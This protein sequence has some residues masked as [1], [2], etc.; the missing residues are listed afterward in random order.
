MENTLTAYWDVAI[1]VYL[2]L[3]TLTLLPTLWA[4]MRK[5]K[6]NPDGDGYDKSAH[7]SNEEKER[8][9]QHYSRIEGT[10]NYWKNQSEKFRTFKNYSILWTIIIT[11]SIPIISQLI[12]KGNS[13]WFLTIISMHGALILGFYRGLKV[14]KNYQAFR[15]AESGFYD[16]RRLLLDNPENLG[17]T[18]KE[19]ID[20][21]FD[22]VRTLR[23]TARKAEIDNT[24]SM[25]EDKEKNA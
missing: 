3:S 22:R 19:Q 17:S 14:E 1:V 21:F 25:D 11:I 8:L 9:K 16:L 18:A 2:I 4:I 5:V 10:L 6:L 7:F 23:K 12:G 15:L 24:P 20:K 13:N